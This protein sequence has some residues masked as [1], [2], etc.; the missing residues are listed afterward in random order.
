MKTFLILDCNTL[1]STVV[2]YT[3]ADM[4]GLASTEQ[5]GR[6]EEGEEGEAV[7]LK[8]SQQEETG[9]AA[10]SLTPDIPCWS[11]THIHIFESSHLEGSYVGDLRHLMAHIS[12][13]RCRLPDLFLP[14]QSLHGGMGG[15]A[16][17]LRHKI[18]LLLSFLG[19]VRIPSHW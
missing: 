14:V 16:W 7:E 1:K 6:L 18:S 10:A 12:P 11:Q 19:A 2:Q 8:D 13:R 4:R 15:D 9:Q 5:A 17:R 3:T